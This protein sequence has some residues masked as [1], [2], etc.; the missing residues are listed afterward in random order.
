MNKNLIKILA[1]FLLLAKSI[2]LLT[3][4][5][6]TTEAY[7]QKKVANI[8]LS[9]ENLQRGGTFNQDRLLS[10]LRTKTGDPFSQ[11]VFDQDLKT[12]SETYDRVESNIETHGGEVYITLKIWQNPI[13]RSILWHGNSKVRT[14]ILQRELDIQPHTLFNRDSFNLAFNKIK[15]YYIKKGYFESEI[16]YKIIPYTDTNEID[17]EITIQEG[18]SG[19]ISKLSFS[20]LTKKEQSDILDLIQTKKYNFF[21]S[22]ITGKGNYHEEA[23]EQDKLII[24]NYLQNQGYA[25]ARVNI[26]TKEN[27]SG[28]LEIAIHAVK[29]EKFYFGKISIEGNELL[30][31]EQIELVM[32]IGEET[33]FSPEQLR[34][35]IQN[36]KDLYGKDGYIQTN[37]N[38]TLHLAANKPIYDVNLHIEEGQQFLIGLVRVLGNVSTN[39]NVIL[40]ES[41]L[42]P[43]EVFDIRRLKTTQTRLE[44]MGYFKSV[45]VYAVKTPE[46]QNL[47]ENY[48][49]VIIEVEETTTGNLSL[50][51][52]LSTSDNIFGGID[53]AEN[54]FNHRGLTNFWR[55]GFASL[56][57]AG[58]YAHLRSQIGKK[59]QNYSIVWMDPYFKDT[60]WRFGFDTNYSTSRLQSDKYRVNTIGGSIFANYP[61]TNYW[62]FGLKWRTRNSVAHIDN[63]IQG[64]EAEQERKNSGLI[65]GINT[66]LSYDT[67]DNPFKPHRGIR[68]Y[69]ELEI[70][71]ARRHANDPR[72]FPFAKISFINT[73]YYPLWRKGTLKLRGDFQFLCPFGKGRSD[74]V[75]LSERFFLGGD[76][77]VRGYKPFSIGPKFNREKDN[78]ES[79]APE[80]GISSMLLSAEYLQ[81]V[82]KMA[83]LFV[84]FDGGS[85]SSKRF[86]VPDFRMSYGFGTR[87]ELGNRM[88][89][90]VG[91]GFPI[92][93]Q[94]KDDVKRFFFSMGAQF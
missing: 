18:H 6:Q 83:D 62:T 27:Q 71:G 2:P 85:I 72:Y 21:T 8:S 29:G 79:N 69:L 48:R 80:G 54:N 92:N 66:S 14:G 20:G 52:G 65:S 4:Y 34:D 58:E 25:D 73:Y 55:E 3:A 93:P 51:G 68:S 75:P 74:T 81:N 30:N 12:L 56:R 31:H 84:F 9:M 7:D 33:I 15:E 45:N 37:V 70:A 10:K 22:W 19:H 61:L 49:D 88:P 78:A 44:M 40:R 77:S 24:T 26:Q 23:L 82:I 38:Y 60:L 16:E 11:N 91:L 86:D 59:Q 35:T 39:K 94:D 89:F 17:I 36:I 63:E 1:L 28:Q 42:V 90:I 5:S 43:G 53:L 41:L 50:F 76:S 87:I 57:G 32:T 13:I 67:T 64:D 46:D 47:G